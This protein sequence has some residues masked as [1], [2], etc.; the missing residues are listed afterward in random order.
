MSLSR[1]ADAIPEASYIIQ[2]KHTKGIFIE[3]VACDIKIRG[4]VDSIVT[5]AASNRIVK[6]IVHMAM[7]LRAKLFANL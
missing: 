2:N 4:E 3:S 6:G 5:T 7:A 1:K